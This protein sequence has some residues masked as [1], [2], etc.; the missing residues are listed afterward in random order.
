VCK[1]HLYPLPLVTR[2]GEGLGLHLAARHIA[3]ILVNITRDL[4]RL[5]PGAASRP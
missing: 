3:G 1:A 5:I 4:A 2:L